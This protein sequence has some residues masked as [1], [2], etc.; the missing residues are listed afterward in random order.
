MKKLSL[1]AFTLLFAFAVF[2]QNSSFSFNGTNS[3]VDLGN[4]VADNVRTIEMW[5]YSNIPITPNLN[6]Y[7]LPLHRNTNGCGNCDELAFAFMP[8]YAASNQGRFRFKLNDGQSRVYDVVSNSSTWADSTWYHIAVVI[9]PNQGILLFIDGVRQSDSE[10]A[11]TSPTTASSVIT[12]LGR[13]GNS[14]VRY[15]DGMLDDVRFSTNAR[16]SN[17]FTPPCQLTTDANTKALYKFDVINSTTTPD[18]SSNQFN[19][20]VHNISL[21][22]V[23]PCVISTDLKEFSDDLDLR[24]YPNPFEDRI[25]VKLDGL[26]QGSFYRL[27]LISATGRLVLD[28]QMNTELHSISTNQLPKGAY[29]LRV[30]KDGVLVKTQKLIK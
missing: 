22:P 6:D 23:V 15:F 14:S 24:V 20:T 16:Y 18:L 2:S 5:V 3:Y 13:Q 17:N 25:D 10:G 7:Q 11:Y 29:F 26:D 12:A 19:A 30:E 1:F 4:T 8:S 9:D 21:N 28:E 27:T